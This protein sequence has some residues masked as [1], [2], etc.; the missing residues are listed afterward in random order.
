MVDGLTPGAAYSVR[1]HFAETYWAAAKLRV[2]DVR[3]NGAQALADFDIFAE[4][5]GAA[6]AVARTFATVADANGTITI[7]FDA[8][9]DN[10][11]INGIE[12][13]QEGGLRPGP[14]EVRIVEHAGW[15]QLSPFD[16]DLQLLVPDDDDILSFDGTP[17][18][19]DVADYDGDGV[20][21]IAT[22]VNGASYQIQIVYGGSGNTSQIG[23]EA[24]MACRW[25]PATSPATVARASPCSTSSAASRCSRTRGV[26]RSARPT[27]GASRTSRL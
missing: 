25:S 2:F 27:S 12:I 21:D 20:L 10:A 24:T 8:S 5:G 4:A 26:G 7:A 9:V 17:V 13:F 15:R 22:L 6:I 14:Y 1:L 11:Q 19:V 3:I 23:R 18:S 16:S